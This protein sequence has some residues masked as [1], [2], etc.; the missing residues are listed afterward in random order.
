[1]NTRKLTAKRLVETLI[2]VML[3][4]IMMVTTAL[5]EDAPKT[6]KGDKDKVVRQIVDNWIQIGTEQYKR[7]FYAAAEKSFMRAKDYEES[8]TTEERTKLNESLQKA[9]KAAVEL[10]T[11]Q[12]AKTEAK[13][14]VEQPKGQAAVEVNEVNKVAEPAPVIEKTPEVEVAPPSA[15]PEEEQGYIGVVNGA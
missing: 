1:M 5:A 10:E 13:P 3:T 8:L 9:H 14:V 11:A 12:T 7:G 2:L 4:S 15:Q 6:D